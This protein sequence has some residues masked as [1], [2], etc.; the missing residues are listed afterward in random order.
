M[1]KQASLISDDIPHSFR[2]PP[3]KTNF[4]FTFPTLFQRLKAL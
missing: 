2:I 1:N 3:Q 4:T